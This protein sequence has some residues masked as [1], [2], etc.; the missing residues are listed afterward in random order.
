V[1]QALR[2]AA[3]SE[4]EGDIVMA[5]TSPAMTE[6]PDFPDRSFL[7]ILNHAKLARSKSEAGEIVRMNEVGGGRYYKFSALKPLKI[8]E[9]AKKRIWKN[10]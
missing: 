3:R 8:N 7:K 1:S 6:T 4:T 5:R 2:L 10:L 9:T